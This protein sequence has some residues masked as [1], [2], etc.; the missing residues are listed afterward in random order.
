[1][2]PARQV[3]RPRPLACTLPISKET[4]GLLAKIKD[5]GETWDQLVMWLYKV[6]VDESRINPDAV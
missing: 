6:A 5:K 3:K 4:R 2:R 1:M